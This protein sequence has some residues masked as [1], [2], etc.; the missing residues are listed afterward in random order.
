MGKID[1]RQGTKI[2]FYS[3]GSARF[4][5]PSRERKSSA[6]SIVKGTKMAARVILRSF[7]LISRRRQYPCVLYVSFYYYYYYYFLSL[8]F[9]LAFYERFKIRQE[10]AELGISYFSYIRR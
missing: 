1:P 9:S 7:V 4:R 10:Q 3:R 2:R 8:S 5:A 6:V